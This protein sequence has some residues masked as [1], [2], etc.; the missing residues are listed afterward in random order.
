MIT[1]RICL[2][3]TYFA[4]HNTLYVIPI[5]C[6]KWQNFIEKRLLLGMFLLD[7]ENPISSVDIVRLKGSFIT[8]RMKGEE[9]WV[10][11]LASNS[12]SLTITS[13][14]GQHVPAVSAVATAAPCHTQMPAGGSQPLGRSLQ[15]SCWCWIL[16][17]TSPDSVLLCFFFWVLLPA[18]RPPCPLQPRPGFSLSLSLL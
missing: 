16:N 6:C 1:Y 7:L 4:R 9:S 18:D 15:P 2:S 8:Y 10:Q 11:E 14:E 12:S 13:R 3:L 5:H 17:L